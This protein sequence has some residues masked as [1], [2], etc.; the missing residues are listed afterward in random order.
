MQAYVQPPCPLLLWLCSIG[1]YRTNSERN[2]GKLILDIST[3]NT[4]VTQLIAPTD[5]QAGMV[6]AAVNFTV[7]LVFA[8]TLD[9]VSADHSSMP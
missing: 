5:P 2:E 3:N 9:G 7:I 4:R 6:A 1:K 8:I